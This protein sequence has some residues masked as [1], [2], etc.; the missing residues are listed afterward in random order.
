M[1]ADG[2][3]SSYYITFKSPLNNFFDLH[4]NI[5]ATSLSGGKPP[6]SLLTSDE[7]IEWFHSNIAGGHDAFGRKR[8][9]YGNALL[10]YKDVNN[11][12]LKFKNGDFIMSEIS[13][14]INYYP[15]LNYKKFFFNLSALTSISRLKN[16]WYFD[17][18]FS[19]SAIKKFKWNKNYLDWGISSGILFPAIF[20]THEVII[21]NIDYLFSGETHLNYRITSKNSNAYILGINFHA[22][23]NFHSMKE[24]QYNVIYHEGVT[25][26]DHYGVS[27][28]NR[29]LNGWTIL[30]GHDW[31]KT[32]ISAFFREDFWV[33]NSPDAQVGWGFKR[34]F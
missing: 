28:L 18:G 3:F 32:S 10:S 14:Y 27:H 26:H 33:D 22:Q 8:T 9:D 16:T 24:R 13:N 1:Y 4:T 6:Y 12:N 20:Q 23:S 21:N 31:K 2:I 19:G 29:W 11:N 30:V 5:R 25:S 34:K 17:M 15:K 7:C